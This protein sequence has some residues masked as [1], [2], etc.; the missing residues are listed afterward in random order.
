MRISRVLAIRQHVS[1]DI[2]SLEKLAQETG[3][4]PGRNA[5]R[6]SPEDQLL[7]KALLENAL[8]RYAEIK[9][10]QTF[11]TKLKSLICISS[12]YGAFSRW[13]LLFLSLL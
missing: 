5:I 3:W 9:G 12:D 4:T 6:P 8:S 10:N 13:R 2:E 7:K 11:C 1:C